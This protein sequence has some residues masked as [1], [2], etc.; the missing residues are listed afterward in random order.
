[1]IDVWPV[2]RGKPGL[3]F[4]WILIWLLTH[5]PKMLTPHQLS[6]AH[7][8]TQQQQLSDPNPAKSWQGRVSSFLHNEWEH[9][10]WNHVLIRAFI[11]INLIEHSAFCNTFLP[12]KGEKKAMA[13]EEKHPENSAWNEHKCYFSIMFSAFLSPASTESNL[14]VPVFLQWITGK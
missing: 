1:M 13:E 2:A 14:L 10:I 6:A 9:Q 7:Q 12:I 8:E 4:R 3:W 5:R 11:L